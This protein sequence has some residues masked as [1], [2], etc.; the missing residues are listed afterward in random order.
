M[1][2]ELTERV[3]GESLH[4]TSATTSCNRFRVS[5]MKPFHECVLEKGSYPLG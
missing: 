1:R 3:A 2:E 5:N 4:H